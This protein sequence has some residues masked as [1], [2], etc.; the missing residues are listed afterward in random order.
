[1]AVKRKVVLI[2]IQGKSYIVKS[3]K[4]GNLKE[5]HICVNCKKPFL[6]NRST[7]KYCSDAC[8]IKYYRSMGYI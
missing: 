7:A 3:S 6:S 2:E 1:M 4:R 5:K 8:R